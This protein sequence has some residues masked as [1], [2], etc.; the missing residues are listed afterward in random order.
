MWHS[1]SN[2]CFKNGTQQVVGVTNSQ[3]QC[4]PG[5]TNHQTADM[6]HVWVFDNPDGALAMDL[7]KQDYTAAYKQ[8]MSGSQWCQ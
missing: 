4:A 2:L 3:D 5:A 1:H 8:C 7:T 6:M